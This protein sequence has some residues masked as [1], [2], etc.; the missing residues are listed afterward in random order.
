LEIDYEFQP[1]QAKLYNLYEFGSATRIG[2]GGS[3]GGTKSATSDIL[4]L[5]RRAKY[6]KTNGLFVMKVYQDMTDIHL[7]PL[8]QRYPELENNFNKQDMILRLPNGSY[9][10]FLSG[11]NLKSFQQRKGREFA[12]IVIDQSELFTQ[13]EL[14]FLTTINRSTNLDITPKMMFCFNPGNIGHTYHKR[15]FYD[16]IYEANEKAEDWAFIQTFGWDN[17]YWC[18]KSLITDGLTMGDYHKWSSDKRFNYFITRSDYGK[19]L[20]RQQ[21][22]KRKAEL[23]GDMD[24]FEG[25][26]FS[27]FRRDTHVINYEIK[28]EWNTIGGLDYGNVTCLEIMQRDYEGSIVA[29]SECYLPD[30][31]NPSDRA[32]AIADHLIENEFFNLK[33]IHDTDMEISQLSNVGY[34]KT[35]IEIFRS[36]FKQR[37]GDK[38]PAMLCVNKT[39]L[40]RNKGYRAVVNEAVKEYL[41]INKEGRPKLFFSSAVK[42]LIKC[43]SELIYDSADKSGVDFDRSSNPKKDHQYDGFKYGFMNLYTPINQKAVEEQYQAS[44]RDIAYPQIELDKEKVSDGDLYF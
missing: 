17:A 7:T 41:H 16:K 24:I 19:T 33:I 12:D 26:F 23:L 20:D 6:P 35:P 3:R 42:H 34:D 30:M 44:L 14:E 1:V 18:Q 11:D 5:L 25:M 22:S 38:A 29:C 36:V 21:D 13:E 28:K 27:D 32:N 15:V 2:F 10:R 37:M 9:I 4:M 40:D 8:F 43:V 31:T 39:S